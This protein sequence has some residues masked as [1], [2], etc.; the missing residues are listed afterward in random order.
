MAEISDLHVLG[1]L[2]LSAKIL[3]D[4]S[5]Q[6][7][8]SARKARLVRLRQGRPINV[9]AGFASNREYSACLD[10]NDFGLWPGFWRWG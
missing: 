7:A 5:R 1:A 6:H 10:I 3:I 4:M 8:C 9:R 2:A